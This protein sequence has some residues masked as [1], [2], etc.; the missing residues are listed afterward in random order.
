MCP[1]IM[2]FLV[3]T[4]SRQSVYCI[5]LIFAYFTCYQY[6]AHFGNLLC[7][8]TSDPY[9]CMLDIHFLITSR[10][11]VILATNNYTYTIITA[12][13]FRQMSDYILCRLTIFNRS[14]IKRGE[15]HFQEGHK[16]KVKDSLTTSYAYIINMWRTV[17]QD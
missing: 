11:L 8:T 13:N 10:Q 14:W 4:Y 16:N 2:H 1:D 5:C 17:K 6:H 3:L 9:I 15:P 12:G 7:G